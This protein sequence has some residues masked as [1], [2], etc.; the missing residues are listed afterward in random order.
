MIKE[1]DK[2]ETI[3]DRAGQA[4]RAELTRLLKDYFTELGL[5]FEDKLDYD[6]ADPLA[7][8]ADGAML[9]VR[10]G[11]GLIGCLGLRRLIEAGPDTAEIKRTYLAPEV[12]GRGL[13]EKLLDKAM[14]TAQEQ[15]FRRIV[16]DTMS[17]LTA[18]N[19]LYRAYGFVDIPRYNANH[20]ADV[21]MEF[22]LD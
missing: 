1:R 20:R 15:G 16:L 19:R 4:D 17:R 5:T 14:I 12:R 2:D 11:D 3:I 9:V 10:R 8:Y 21:F 7:G 6:M 18:A 13:A 22:V